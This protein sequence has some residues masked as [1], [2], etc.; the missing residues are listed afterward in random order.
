MIQKRYKFIKP[1][2]SIDGTIPVGKQLDVVGEN[3]F[4]EGWMIEPSFY[5]EFKQLI[6][7]EAKKPHYLRQVPIPYNK[8]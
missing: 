2:Q 3:I 5:E 1:Y 8:V 6:L 7:R 4:F